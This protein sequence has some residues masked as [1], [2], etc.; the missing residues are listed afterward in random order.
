[1]S[2]RTGKI[3][4][5]QIDRLYPYQVEIVDPPAG[6]GRRIDDLYA[7]LH[8]HGYAFKTHGGSDRRAE[9]ELLRSQIHI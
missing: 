2:R 8:E 3:T 4:K 9:G 7:F 1:M 6:P 5:S